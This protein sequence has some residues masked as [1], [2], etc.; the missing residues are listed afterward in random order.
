[1]VLVDVTC[2][3]GALAAPPAV[4][5]PNA[6]PESF[7]I[8]VEIRSQS[9]GRIKKFYE[10]RNF[11]PIWVSSG[12]IGPEAEMLLNLL[13]TAELDGLKPSSY[14]VEKLRKLL[15]AARIGDVA[16]M[17]RAEVQ[18]A[19]SFSR[20]ISD[21]R[22][23]SKQMKSYLSGELKPKKLKAEMVLASAALAG[24]LGT[25]VSSMGW[26]N[27]HYKV[28]RT[29]LARAKS[30]GRSESDVR[31]LQLNMERA[32]VLPGPW[33]H[34]IVVDAAAGQ[35]SYFQA[36]KEKGRMRVI[37]GKPT[38]PTPMLAGMIHYAILNPYWNVPADLA[39]S[40]IAP[41]ILAGKT[42]QSMNIEALSDWSA[43][44]VTLNPSAIDWPSV[45]SGAQEIR[46]RQ[47][48]G[49]SNSMGRVKFM[50]P[51]EQGIYLHDTPDKNLL[52]KADRHLSNGCIRLENAAKLGEWLLGVPIKKLSKLPE[53][54]KALPQPVPVYLTY[55]SA[56][57]SKDGVAFLPDVYNRDQ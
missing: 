11:A 22:R 39:Q 46:L 24:P 7:A 52:S 9:G 5:L 45:A 28:F 15:D 12:A 4:Q 16:S 17:A 10:A 55:F 38:T 34:H 49:A 37:V 2:F 32:R 36:G 31:R 56:I 35:L 53:Q 51:N 19:D 14:K 40:L 43:T 48:P 41:K 13:A 50:F 47:L 29:L 44:P 6:L 42:L 8:N 26:T 20:Y 21:M 57:E 27:P 3:A 1:M 18:L 30:E 23:P 25:Y 33:T 54:I